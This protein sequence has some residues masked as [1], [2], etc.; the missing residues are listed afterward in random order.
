[1]PYL[2]RQNCCKKHEFKTGEIRPKFVHLL[3]SVSFFRKLP[4]E[5]V[6]QIDH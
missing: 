2:Q 6:K 3:I 4:I 5:I 1:M